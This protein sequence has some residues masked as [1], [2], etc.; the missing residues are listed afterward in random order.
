MGF[1]A[2]TVVVLSDSIRALEAGTLIQLPSQLSPSLAI[3]ETQSHWI[4]WVQEALSS[5]AFLVSLPFL[6]FISQHF[7]I[8]PEVVFAHGDRNGR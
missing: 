4:Q 1:A 8:L 5:V 7:L 6:C 2:H 3:P